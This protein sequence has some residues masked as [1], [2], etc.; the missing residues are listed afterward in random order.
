MEGDLGA[1]RG[2]ASHV[3]PGET[4]LHP[5]QSTQFPS[6]TMVRAEFNQI[7]ALRTDSNATAIEGVQ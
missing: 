3:L 5:I 1:H 4:P 6:L 7:D 2:C